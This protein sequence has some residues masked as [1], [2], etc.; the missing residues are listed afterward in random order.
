MAE[1]SHKTLTTHPLKY[2]PQLRIDPELFQQRF[3]LTC[4]M[5]QCNGTCC[6]EGVLLDVAEKERILDSAGL[7]KRYLEPQQEHD[8]AKWFENTIEY[9]RDFPSGQCDST[10]VHNDG[11][12]FLDSKGLC[13]LQKTAMTEGMDKFALKPFYCVAFPLV[14][15]GH[16]LTTDDPDFTKR[17]ECCCADPAGTL[18]VFDVC[19]EEFEFVLGA[20]GF[21]EIENM[22]TEKAVSS[23]ES[24]A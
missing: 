21:R 17:T 19:R 20:E 1:V 24:I 14:I 5:C 9:D 13:V 16:M 11:C 8:E 3:S 6:S 23:V 12:V 18:T 4:S 22:F 2:I 15:D 10:V 7:I